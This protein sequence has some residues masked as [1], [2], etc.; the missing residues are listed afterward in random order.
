MIDSNRENMMILI[1]ETNFPHKLKLIDRQ[2]LKLLKVIAN[3]SSA[4][5]KL[6]KNQQ[7]KIV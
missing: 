5:T 3:N 4:N 1:N 6:L 2:V 7:S